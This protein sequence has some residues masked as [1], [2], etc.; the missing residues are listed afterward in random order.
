MRRVS[1][2]GDKKK[3][4]PASTLSPHPDKENDD[5][6]TRPRKSVSKGQL[7]VLWVCFGLATWFWM[8]E[9]DFIS[10][11]VQEQSLRQGSKSK[12]MEAQRLHLHSKLKT[13]LNVYTKQLNKLKYDP[14]LE[15]SVRHAVRDVMEDVR[16]VLDARPHGEFQKVHS[17]FKEDLKV[18]TKQLLALRDSPT[19]QRS[20]RRT[21]EDVVEDLG[22]I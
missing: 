22:G 20:V 17:S 15:K 8:S 5:P 1:L 19:L 21:V 10:H 7:C 12:E 6:G 4:T 11:K 3:T 13:D 18:Y 14:A 16:D 2:G 9:P